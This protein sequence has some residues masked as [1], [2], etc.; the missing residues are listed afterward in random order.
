MS[1]CIGLSLALVLSCDGET[2]VSSI[3]ATPT[4]DASVADADLASSTDAAPARSRLMYISTGAGNTLK[5]VELQADGSM[6]AKSELDIDLG[7]RTGA[8]AFA[9]TSR[10]L[11]VGVG[12]DIVTVSLDQAGAPSLVGRSLNTGNPVYLEVAE[13]ESV[14]VSAYFGL[15]A[16]KSHDIT[17]NPPH[18][19]LQ[20]LGS[21]DE[22]HL[23]ITGPGSRIYVPHRTGNTTQWFSLSSAGQLAFQGELLGEPGVGPRHMVFAPNADYAYVINEFADSV[24]SHTVAG[25]GALSRV[26][27]LPTIP[28]SFDGDNNTCADVHVTPDGKYL[29]G[30]N[31]GHDSLAMF[32]IGATGL[33]T[34]LGTI[35][36]ETTPREFDVSPDGRFVVVAGQGN[37]FLQSYRVQNDGTLV[38][39]DRIEVGNDPR[40]VIVE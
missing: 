31:R 25:D 1:R 7:G 27:T 28:D 39:V 3:D 20:S 17:A 8:M 11:F 35:P 19:E 26:E 18:A 5:V 9:R 34:S 12:Q 10:R 24:S 33:L 40:W 30:S 14:L 6:V 22:P 16:L 23:A 15:D 38:S 4:I 29:Y 37:G 13:N 21:A 32:S 2:I 36:T